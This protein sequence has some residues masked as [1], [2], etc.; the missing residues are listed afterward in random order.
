VTKK[1]RKIIRWIV[2]IIAA[3]VLWFL[4][5]LG[6]NLL[7]PVAISQL[8]QLTGARVDINDV[9]FH[10]SGRIS[11]KDISI[12]PLV[13]LEPDNAILTA[14]RLDAYFSP[15]SFLKFSPKLDRVRI[16]DFV[17]NIQFNGD[18]KEWNVA[19]LKVPAK[20]KGQILPELRFK[21]GEIKFAQINKGVEIKTV[22]CNINGGH[23]TAIAENGEMLFNVTE[24]NPKEK[25]GNSITVKWTQKDV[26]KISVEGNLPR[27]K[28]ALFGSKCNV[29]SFYSNIIIDENKITFGKSS[30]AIGPQTIID[31]NGTITDYKTDPAFVFGVKMKDLN[32]R[33]DPADNCFAFGSRIFESFIPLLQVFFDNFN[34][35]GRLGLDVV[36]TGRAKEIAKTRCDGF[37]D[38]KDISIQF[39]QFPYLVEHLA[40]KIDVTETSMKMKNMKASHGK[41]D[42]EMNGY[43]N[44]FGEAMDSNIVMTSNNM[45][46]DEDLYAALMPNHKKLWYLF[47]PAG[48]VSG[49]FIYA[50]KPPGQ[51]IFRLNANLLDVSIICHY[52][53][54]PVS[55]ITGKIW[56]DGGRIGLKDVLSRQS[57]GTIEMD[58]NITDANTADPKYDFKILAKN[59]AIDNKLIN[60]F[61]ADQK[62]FFNNFDIQA[63]GDAD[64]YVHSTDNNEMPVDYLAKLNIKGEKITTPKLPQPLKNLILDA[65][66]TPQAFE[67]KKL[68]ADFNSSP[69]NASGTIW[70]ETE[71]EPMGYC[72]RLTAGNLALDSNMV[73]PILGGNSAG[74]LD[75]FQFDGEVNVDALVGKNSRI[76]CPEF[77]IGIECLNDSAYLSK[78]DLPLED[79]T[80][81]III[82]PEN[83]ELVSLSAVPVVD[84][85]NKPGKI[86]LNGK[87][88]IAK[89]EVDWANLKLTA[90]DLNF[91]NRYM[92][93]LGTAETYYDKLAPQGNIDLSLDRITFE[94]S[95]TGQKTIK[96]SGTALFKNCSIGNTKPVSNIYAM[97]NIDTQYDIGVG[98]K[99]CKL[100]LE[101]QSLSFKGRPIENMR[102]KVPYDINNPDV[103]ISDF[104]GDCLGGRIAGDAFIKT[105]SK[106][107]FSEYN[108]DIAV[109]G[110][111]SEK[112]MSPGAAEKSGGSLNGEIRVKGD[113]RDPQTSR[114]RV[115]IAATGI[116]LGSKNLVSNIRNAILEAI[117][118]DLAFDNVK[119][120]AVVKGPMVEISRMDL[121]GPTASLRGT[122]T[123][124]PAADSISV[125]FVAYSGAGKDKASFFDTLT[126]GF[127]AAFLKVYVRGTL[128][129]PEIKVEPL[130]ILKQT[131]QIIGTK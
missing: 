100:M 109:V 47:S 29:N 26:Q 121:Y 56:V 96:L 116:Q 38:C 21:R 39:Y 66:L 35:Q 78:F 55:G 99:D 83:I 52:F 18:K 88:Q 110:V 23:T 127:G 61:P 41:V 20:K 130:P 12:G 40:G 60:S 124:D 91:D 77:E 3:V 11:F 1:N 17:V 7:K 16:S 104:V 14:K 54:Y 80:G 123:Y 115:I 43:C 106:G 113:F 4:Y 105:D 64:I 82:N 122:G 42:I 58:G 85:M 36:L 120:Q 22:S 24:D 103:V 62:K 87:M 2:I 72:M 30:V 32:I 86:T 94:K 8:K 131:L 128:E 48:M 31:V 6:G 65:N 93:L 98:M 70:T 126:S 118:K 125:D 84:D 34:P 112:F 95:E 97:L 9:A 107:G 92:S 25:A 119:V 44:G 111:S 27:L 57:G 81:K 37:L 53:P 13:K 67:I 74:L 50:A 10:L 101:V 45:L 63:R 73:K 68:T 102:L 46:L 117:K 59:V 90:V 89:G 114:G 69:I 33:R 79:I 5:N 129:E 19:S 15:W 49:D 75:E 76:K 71:A 108:I 28:L 51:R